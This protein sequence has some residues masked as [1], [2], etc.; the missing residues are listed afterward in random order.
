M[1]D[2]CLKKINKKISII[3]SSESEVEFEPQQN[4]YE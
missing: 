2:V 3:F 4:I 1:K